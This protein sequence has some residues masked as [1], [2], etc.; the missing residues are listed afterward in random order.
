MLN[1]VSA[2]W[3]RYILGF[4]RGALGLRHQTI[5]HLQFEFYVPGMRRK[6]GTILNSFFFILAVALNSSLALGQDNVALLVENGT[7]N[8]LTAEINQYK[9]DVESHFP[10]K[11][12]IVAGQW[13]SPIEVRTALKNSYQHDHIVGAVL[14]GDIPMHRFFIHGSPR[15]NPLY[16]EALDAP[17]SDDDHD[18]VDDHYQWSP[19]MMKIWAANI[20][21]EVAEHD[22]EIETL[23]Q[24]FVKTHKYYSG[25]T[26]F[27]DRALAIT[28]KDWPDGADIFAAYPG[29]ALFGDHIDI[30][31]LPT[32]AFIRQA[33]AEH[34]Y[35][36]FYIQ[37]HSTWE[38][39]DLEDGSLKAEEIR[40]FK[41]GSLI[42]I[43]H[44][45][46]TCDWVGA[47][48]DPRK[49]NTGMSWVFGQGQ[50]EAL[51]GNVRSGM[52]YGQET[53]YRDLLAQNYLGQAYFAGK[54]TAE[55]MMHQDYPK[56]EIISGLTL[57]G[58]P[59]LY[60]KSS[61]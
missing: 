8:Q 15:P 35:T 48:E 24:F 20:R 28:D 43:N 1:K 23:R 7:H 30:C 40:A 55:A 33:M 59:F 46:S 44:G 2:G 54:K 57:I 51:I 49:I 36:L 4:S 5:E 9:D 60:P 27:E 53:I 17:F 47:A 41:T 61:Y 29:R 11:V 25:Q 18:G 45:C 31:R 37:V 50:G 56:G 3:M 34:T 52:V 16:Y 12:L 32:L 10:V 58:N 13:N 21:G 38:R 22:P 39:Q 26:R 14:V 6:L 42:T 19:D